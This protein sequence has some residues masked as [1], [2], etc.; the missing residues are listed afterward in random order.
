WCMAAA[1]RLGAAFMMGMYESGSSL[2]AR[3]LA[4]EPEEAAV[5]PYV[6]GLVS[7]LSLFMWYGMPEP[8]RTYFARLEAL[9]PRI[10]ASPLA[11]CWTVWGGAC[12]RDTRGGPELEETL[13]ACERARE[14]FRSAGDNRT[15]GFVET[16]LM[17]VRIQLGAAEEAEARMREALL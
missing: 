4:A 5:G 6:L 3:L 9:A 2:E 8:S 7:Q 10:P 14:A 15:V 11:A 13:H 12:A 16:L 17:L 1:T